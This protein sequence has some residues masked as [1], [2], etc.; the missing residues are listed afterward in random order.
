MAL[1][2]T[3][4]PD[5][6]FEAGRITAEEG[7]ALGIHL[8]LAPVADV[9]NN[10][11][12]PIINTRSFGEDPEQVSLYARRFMQ[13]LQS[14]G[15]LATAKHFPGHGDT[16]T[17]SHSS[18]ARIPES[19]ERL[20]SVELK[21]FQALIDGGVDLVMVG[22]LDAGRFQEEPGVPATLSPFMLR[23]ILRKRMGFRGA[24]ITDGMGMGGITEGYSDR[25]ALIQT[26]KAG[27]DIIIQNYDFKKSVDV[28]AKA[29]QD[30]LLTESRIDDA[31]LR[32]LTL[33]S[34]LGL[35]R[36]RLVSLEKMMTTYGTPYNRSV[37]AQIM[38]K[39]ITLVK[40]SL[41]Q[42]PLAAFP[43][44]T[45]YIIDIRDRR[46]DHDR[47]TVRQQL[48]RHLPRSRSFALDLTDSPGCYADVLAAIPDSAQVI[49]CVFSQTRMKKNRVQLPDIQTQFIH[50]LSQRTERLTVVSFGSPYLIRSFPE[51][52]TSEASAVA[53]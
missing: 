2:A 21:P 44:D 8:A 25:F 6:A 53:S 42:I 7:R 19:P 48:E 3:G 33:K 12:N 23:D 46:A 29:V 15:M 20:W 9:N 30:G 34:R 18:L 36:E 47:S 35:D 37:A 51:I 14:H 1:T 24:V 49:A 41:S 27:A 45:V 16:Q 52:P 26:I 32:I 11:E 13:G 5:L 38:Q 4:D 43:A 40:D 28:V 50:N 31:V 22:H 10:P 17:D 39:S